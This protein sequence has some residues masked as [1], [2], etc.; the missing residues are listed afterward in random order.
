MRDTLRVSQQ[1]VLVG[2]F[3]VLLVTA[4]FFAGRTADVRAKS[5]LLLASIYQHCAATNLPFIIA[6]DFNNPVCDF[7]AY[8]AFRAV[9]CQEAFHFAQHQF[10]KT[11]PPTCRGSTRNDTFIVHETLVPLISDIWVGP[12]ALFPDH[13]PLFM[14][15]EF[16]GTQS[17]AKNW[18][19]PASWGDTPF[20]PQTLED[21]YTRSDRRFVPTQ[22]LQSEEAVN[23][24]FLRWSKG[25]EHAVKKCIQVQHK[26]DPVRFPNASLPGK[27]FGRCCPTKYVTHTAPRTVRRDPTLGYDPPVEATSSKSRLKARQTRRLISFTKH[28][29]HLSNIASQPQLFSQLLHEWTVIR[30]AQGYGRSW[31]TWLLSFECIPF[32]PVEL[33]SLEWLSDAVQITRFDADAFARQE[34]SL[35]KHHKKHCIAFAQSHTNNA[36]AYRFIKR[37]EQRFLNDFPVDK[38]THATLCR[39]RHNSP[40]LKMHPPIHLPIGAKI[41]F[42]TCTATVQSL[43]TPFVTLH[44]VEGILP[45]QGE[46][47][48]RTHAYTIQDMSQSF[49]SFWSQFWQRDSPHEQSADEPWSD[50]LDDLDDTV[51][52]QPM[53]DIKIDDPACLWET[54]RRLKSHKAPGVDGWH[55]EELQAL[56][57]TMVVDLSK[58][59]GCVWSSCLTRRLMQARTLLFAKRDNP[60]SIS[61]GRPITILGYLSR[62]CSKL[63]SDQILQH[64]AQTWPPEI[65]GGLPRRSA[66]SFY[67]AATSDR[68]C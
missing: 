53:L 38:S 45:G 34:A 56:T 22:S 2:H 30:R 25:V 59:L 10:G 20:D 9:R 57:R 41:L 46:L 24:A 3:E 18:F 40:K 21:C 62:L 65:S 35:R 61:D 16:P 13:R 52:L 63:V 5:D 37:K 49:H 66:R 14:Q 54:I 43:T 7:P 47:H 67:Y 32:V 31:E 51:P 39:A 19:I 28:I 6:A 48:F 50:L 17:V 64:W 42:G 15:L 12:D 8:A 55:A 58:L 23:D 1:I 27:Y 4:Y 68:T 33:P 29:K 44:N 26:N 36:G 11:L 60:A